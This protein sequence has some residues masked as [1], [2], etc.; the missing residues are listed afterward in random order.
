MR[1]LGVSRTPVREAILILE[2]EGFLLH[3]PGVG[4]I[5]MALG[6]RELE[7]AFEVREMLECSAVA[8]AA[9]RITAPQLAE[10]KEICRRYELVAR[11]VR[12]E[13]NPGEEISEQK[14]QTNVLD[15]LFHMKIT[16]AADNR[17]LLKMVSDSH[18]F[19]RIFSRPA[20]SPSMPHL[21]R[22][23]LNHRDHGRILRALV[24]HDVAAAVHWMRADVSRARDFH[25]Q[26]FDWEQ[27]QQKTRGNAVNNRQFP[28]SIL[29]VLD[30]I[31][32]GSL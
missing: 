29:Q 16:A 19:T 3:K 27:A 1:E 22:V 24:K 26:S 14:T 23:S 6:R 28:S 7:E 18:L 9:E 31:E 10:L 12:K 4:V 21:R 32:R 25:L 20:M 15:L 17:R 5:T 11:D 2:S 13:K 8:M 30:Q